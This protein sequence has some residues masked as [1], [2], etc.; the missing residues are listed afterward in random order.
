[1]NDLD[2]IVKHLSLSERVAQL[3]EE[4][5]ELAQAAMKYRR[6]LDG[7]NPTP[8]TLE[9]ACDNLDEEV[10][11][12]LACLAS[13]TS[14]SAMAEHWLDWNMSVGKKAARWRQRLEERGRGGDGEKPVV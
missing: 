6:A 4:A 1:M 14:P 10:A 13:L 2:Y 7:V 11:D 9:Q 12:V 3:A 8:V 5:A